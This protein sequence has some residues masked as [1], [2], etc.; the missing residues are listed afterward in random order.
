MSVKTLSRL[1]VVVVTIAA[2]GVIASPSAFASSIEFETN[3]PSVGGDLTVTVKLTNLDDPSTAQISVFS[4]SNCSGTPV[5]SS[6]VFNS[7]ASSATYNY[8]LTNVQ[9]AGQ[10]T[11]AVDLD[12]NGTSAPAP[13][14]TCSDPVT[15]SKV[16]PSLTTVGSNGNTNGVVHNTATI[17]NRKAQQNNQA[18]VKLAFGLYAPNDTNCTGTPVGTSL[19]TVGAST[20]IYASDPIKV[21]SAGTYR[22]KVVYSGDI[23]NNAVTSPCGASKSVVTSGGTPSGVTCDGFPATIVGSSKGET[24]IGTSARDVIVAKGGNDVVNGKGGDDVICGG[25]GKDI[26]R[27]GGGND[28]IF[29]GAKSDDVQGGKGN[30]E[31]HGD[32]GGDRVVGGP[33]NDKLYGGKG[34]DGLDGGKGTDFGDGGPGTDVPRSIERVPA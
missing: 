26:L 30:D 11:W 17:S 22:W 5:Q 27:G 21:T 20:T 18:G 9:P 34:N 2:A 31:L 33:G 4:N 29:G 28:V 15:V 25:D 1:G 32:A 16:T 12:E 6:Q 3:S 7:N 10:W 23:N 24:I 13:A 14:R 19:K 8:K